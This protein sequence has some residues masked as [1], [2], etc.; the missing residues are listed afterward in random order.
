MITLYLKYIN[1]FNIINFQSKR[2]I[3]IIL[4]IFIKE[5]FYFR[6]QIQIASSELTI[7]KV[8]F[9]LIRWI[10]KGFYIGHTEPKSLSVITLIEIVI[11]KWLTLQILNISQKTFLEIIKSIT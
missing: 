2:N 7:K 9:K 8:Q 3:L 11:I 10:F 6:D 5:K 1:H 4:N